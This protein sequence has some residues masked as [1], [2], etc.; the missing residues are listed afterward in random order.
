M[1]SYI[2]APF[3][4]NFSLGVLNPH[5]PVCGFYCS[6]INTTIR[7]PNSRK[8]VTSELWST[9]RSRHP[10]CNIFSKKRDKHFLNS[11]ELSTFFF[12][13]LTIFFRI[14]VPSLNKLDAFLSRILEGS[15]S[16]FEH[17]YIS[18]SALALSL[19]IGTDSSSVLLT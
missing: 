8:F 10:Y 4:P 16:R 3:L 7:I 2:Y 5:V 6:K 17:V 14:T 11:N 19:E 13:Q 15:L 18:D 12:K 1:C 9:C